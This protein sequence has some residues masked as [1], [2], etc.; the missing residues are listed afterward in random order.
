MI[1]FVT[2][3]TLQHEY[4]IIGYRYV[5]HLQAIIIHTTIPKNNLFVIDNPFQHLWPLR[6]KVK[7]A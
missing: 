6:N 1:R 7:L 2:F 3:M 5:Q 4:I